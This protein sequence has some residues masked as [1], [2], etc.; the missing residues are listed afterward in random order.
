M[1]KNLIFV[2]LL[3]I[4]CTVLG[5]LVRRGDGE[6]LKRDGGNTVRYTRWND[7][8]K[9]DIYYLDRHYMDSGNNIMIKFR[10]ERSGNSIRYRYECSLETGYSITHHN[11]NWNDVSSKTR[12]SVIFLDRHTVKCSDSQALSG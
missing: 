12:E 5:K 9:G 11:T 10:L 3:I 7:S 1:N 4:C 6:M 2:I 8:G